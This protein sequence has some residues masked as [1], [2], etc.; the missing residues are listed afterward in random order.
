MKLSPQLSMVSLALIASFT[1]QAN[2]T[3]VDEVIVISGDRFGSV[4]EQQLQV[5]NLIER[6]DIEKLNPKSVVDVLETLPAVTVTRNGGA[7]QNASVSIRGANSSHSLVLVDGLRVSS[8]TTGSVNFTAVMPEQIERIEVIKGPRAAVWGSDAIGGVIH[9]QTRKLAGGEHFATVEAGSNQYGRLT[10]GVGFSHGDGQTGITVSHDRSDGYDV[11][12]DNETDDDGYKRTSVGLSGGQQLSEALRLDWL[13][14]YNIGETEY[15]S[16]YGGNESEYDNYFWNLAGSYNQGKFESK[17]QIG[18]SRDNSDTFRD[19]GSESFGLFQTDRD[20]LNFINQ[21]QFTDALTVIAGVDYINEAV[22]GDFEVDERD[23]TGVFG[24]VRYLGEHLLLEGAVRE[25]S[26]DN[27]NSESTYNLSAGYQF[28]EHWR[29]VATHGTG[30]KAPSFN[31]LYYPNSGNP[32]LLSETSSN[33]DITLSFN[34][35]EFNAYISAYDNE[36]EN[37]ISWAPTGEKDDYGYDIWK[38]A[39]IGKASFQGYELQLKYQ[40]GNM[41]HNLGYHFLD[42]TDE[43]TGEPLT[44]RSEHELTYRIGY[45]LAQWSLNADYRYQG[46][47]FVSSYEEPLDPYHQL[48][49]SVGYEV[50]QSWRIEARVNNLLDESIVSA[51]GYNS[52]GREFYLRVNYIGM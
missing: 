46:E 22:K 33:S 37:L 47:R 31:D 21:Y 27:L 36:I 45:Q 50:S 17:L 12:A 2:N 28:N 6:V 40:Y 42:A 44:D 14:Q 24:L 19:G 30:F 49:M 18:Q 8:A 9:I 3:V 43:T 15:D 35:G 26:V 4:P 38:P 1:A 13:G 39:N 5:V 10:G 25:D 48:G 41:S 51:S 23:Q 11:K 16:N 32:D 52:P 20:Q 29:L 34:Y 7:G